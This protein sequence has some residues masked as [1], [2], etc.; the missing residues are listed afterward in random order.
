MGRYLDPLTR[1]KLFHSILR[2]IFF[3]KIEIPTS[4]TKPYSMNAIPREVIVMVGYPGS[5]KTTIA[6]GLE[7]YHRVDG[8]R[9]KTAAAMKKEAEQYIQ[10]QSIVFDSTAA[11]K[12]KRQEFIALAKKH[13]VPVRAFWVQTPLETSMTR[14]KQRALEGGSNVPPVVF[15]V[16]RKKFEEPTKEEGFTDIVVY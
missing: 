15:Y 4:I 7:G 13:N 8:D 11:T 16:Y 14:N 3:E 6:K 9:L 1:D 12:E 5:G 10:N 2:K